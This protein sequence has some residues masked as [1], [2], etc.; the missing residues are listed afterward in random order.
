MPV[1]SITHWGPETATTEPPPESDGTVETLNERYGVHRVLPLC[2]ECGVRVE[3]Y[4][5][6]GS[7]GDE[8]QTVL[9]EWREKVLIHLRPCNHQVEPESIG[10][11]RYALQTRLVVAN[12]SRP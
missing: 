3:G 10:L 2:P 7:E 12:A 4:A 8:V 6:P 5:Y 9:P 1:V 11:Q